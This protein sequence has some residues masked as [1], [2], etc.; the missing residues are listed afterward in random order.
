MPALGITGGVATGKSTFTA[1]LRRH[2]PAEFFDADQC[3]HELLAQDDAVRAALRGAFGD[4]AFERSGAPNRDWLRQIV[5]AD[6]AKRREL[7]HI[8]HP[9]IRQRWVTRARQAG[10]DRWFCAD[11]PLLFETGAQ[12]HFDA[13]V[14]VACS[15]ATQ[16]A[17]LHQHRHLSPAL[18]EQIIAAQLDLATKISQADHLIWNDST[19]TCLDRQA[20]ILASGLRERRG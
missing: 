6:P 15:P 17:R 9:V 2:W 14:V 12:Q 18:A 20:R 1:A 8:L 13:V 4:A 3:A 16:R 19:D 7:E 11:I 10:T 5:F